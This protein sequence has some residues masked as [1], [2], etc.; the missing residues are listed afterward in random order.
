VTTHTR[1][2]ILVGFAVTLLVLM[3]EVLGVLRGPEW[4][5]VDERFARA[6][7]RLEPMSDRIHH[8]DID[9][10]ALDSVG[11]WPW[12][13][14]RLA[15]AIDEM[16]RAGAA[17]IA[18]DLLF[19]EPEEVQQVGDEMI[20]H[21]AR[22]A[23]ALARSRCVLPVVAFPDA[24]PF[25]PHWS[26]ERGV[27][28]M[29]ALMSI[30][31]K[32]LRI[33]PAAA[34]DRAI[35]TGLRRSS[36]LSRPMQFKR[37]A[38]WQALQE[39]LATSDEPPTAET[40]LRAMAP[41]LDEHVGGFPE[42]AI[43]DGVW[44]Q[45]RAWSLVRPSLRPGAGAG[46]PEDAVPLPILCE[47]VDRVGFVNRET[48][49]DGEIRQVSVLR[50]APGGTAIHFGL[51]AAALFLGLQAS[52]VEARGDGLS[53]GSARLPLRGGRLPLY[54]PTAP[55]G[56]L[57]AFRAA[58]DDLPGVGH[59]SIGAL[60]SLSEQRRALEA[61]LAER[62]RIAWAI[63]ERDEP[64]PGGLSDALAAQVSEQADFLVEQLEQLRAEGAVLSD[65]E[66]AE[67]APYRHWLLLEESIPREREG[68]AAAEATLRQRLGGKLVFIGW[69]AT[70][71]A[72]DFVHTPLGAATP[73]VVV[74]ATVANMALTGR[75]PRFLPEWLMLALTAAMGMMCT[76]IAAR[77]MPATATLVVVA[78]LAA[79]FG[80]AGWWLFGARG[81]LMP[82]VA[83]LGAGAGAWVACTTLAA[84]LYQADRSRITRQFRARVSPQLVDYLVEKPGA[85]SVGGEQREI[86]VMFIDIAGFTAMAEMLGGP[87]TVSTLN[88]LMGELTARIT[89]EHG[90]V[91]KF[92]GDGLMAF[93]SAFRD[94]PEQAR[95]ACAAALGCQQAME[96]LAGDPRFAGLPKLHARIGIATDLVIVG[97]CGAP[98]Q[99]NDYTVI[100]NGVN[101]ASRLESANKQFGT[102][103]L[104]DGRTHALLG[105]DAAT[106]R[107][108]FLGRIV[109]VGQSVPVEIY[110]LARPDVDAR[111]IELTNT[112]VHAFVAG[113]LATSESAWRE[114]MV[115]AGPSK[116][117]SIYLDA[118]AGAG[119]ER[120]GILRLREK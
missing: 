87:M 60:V 18:I 33:E 34:A 46:S 43:I 49:A 70:A 5:T 50:R 16:T 94:D 14:S 68:L 88:V 80:V 99:L 23:A 91:N 101:L 83:P 93:W 96:S 113:D 116:L 30:L 118:I 35:L 51:A 19:T 3:L 81:V 79:Y 31:R 39:L 62:E 77:L 10:G 1:Q 61:K 4:E 92:L 7:W 40:F 9:D 12:H 54:W 27:V 89:A 100:G 107:R 20:D 76:W 8:V 112:A 56:W 6:R 63:L 73:G 25:G 119:A 53:I 41:G 55:A 84:V 71:A 69:T 32:D 52:E 67:I 66:Q 13:R 36:F 15:D 110:E 75:H 114:V 38:A 97:D 57:D 17:V 108:R 28:E 98:P 103:V 26:S 21:D 64:P 115:L 44:S 105:A 102:R 11:R 82:L 65:E 48:D 74:H 120:D 86:S 37:I 29:D 58:A 111:V 42:R 24:A 78:L 45:H 72:A 90:Y 47:Q 22:L 117:A 59:T 95:R 104:I 2:V 85:L 106:P 109:V